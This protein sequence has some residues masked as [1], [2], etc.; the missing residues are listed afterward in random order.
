[1]QQAPAGRQ[2]VDRPCHALQL[3]PPVHRRE[4]RQISTWWASTAISCLDGVGGGHAEPE[5]RGG[6]DGQGLNW[7]ISW[8]GRG[9]LS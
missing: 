5:V 1:M 7:N 3:R 6:W 2:K 8:P 4:G 9:R